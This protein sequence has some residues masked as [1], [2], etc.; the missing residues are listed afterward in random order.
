MVAAIGWPGQWEAHFI[1]GEREMHICGGQQSTHFVLHPG[2]EVRTPLSVIGFYHGDAIDGQNLWRRWML[3]HNV[4]RPAGKPLTPFTA[5]CMGL[6]QDEEGEKRYIDA[7]VKARVRLDYW[8]MDAGWY[9]CIPDW[10][11]IGTWEPDLQRFP[12]GIRAVSDH[13]HAAEMKLVL[14]F[15]PERVRAAT[16]LAKTH[17]EWLLHID[18]NDDYLLNL[19]DETAR[20]W[21]TEHVS[22]FISEQGVD[23]Y[24]QDFNMDP[25][26]YWR[27]HDTP[28]R[29]GVTEMKH[30]AGYLA[31]WDALQAR[32]PALPIDSCA[33]GGRRNDLETLRR[34]VPLLRSDYQ[35]PQAS[36]MTDTPEHC[37]VGNQG[38]TDGLSSWVPFYGTGLP[39]SDD[40]NGK[41]DYRDAYAL[42][43]FLCP[44]LGIGI[45]PLN[46]RADWSQYQRMLAQWRLVAPLMLGDFVPLT[47]Y[48]LAEE[49]WM[50]WQFHREDMQVGVVQFFRHAKSPD[51]SACFPLRGLDATAQYAITELT[52]ETCCEMSGADLMSDGLPVDIPFPRMAV[53][54]LYRQV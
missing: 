26:P 23:L 47:P 22:R 54:L 14:W 6:R 41:Y 34:A 46:P 49:Q 42:Y 50:G 28:D 38:H 21:L 40:P 10:T 32:F 31:Y 18:G 45:D 7:F 5:V 1:G 53:L 3:A 43:S 30:V 48:S 52:S 24:R 15:E 11:Q 4:P 17:P 16:W 44:M 8:W 35:F 33:S 19:G 9:P 37:L 13:A 2:E 20:L 51:C 36:W 12:H 29:L 25:L 27:E 39:F